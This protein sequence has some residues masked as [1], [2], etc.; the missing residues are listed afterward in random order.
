M[1]ALLKMQ[2]KEATIKKGDNFETISIDDVKVHDIVMVKPGESIPVDGIV[3]EGISVV[4]ESMLTGESAPVDKNVNSKVFAGTINKD[5][6][7]LVEAK[8]SRAATALG[9]IIKLV[10][11][12]SASKAP[13]QKLA[14]KVSS[15]F[16]P[17]VLAAAVIS[18]ILWISF[19]DD[20]EKSIISAVSVLVIACPCAL[21]LATPTVILVAVA[22]GA[23][24]GILVKSAEA[25]QNATKMTKLIIDKTGTVTE[26]VVKFDKVFSNDEQAFL[27]IAK[28]LSLRSTHPVSKAIV[29]YAQEKQIQ[30]IGIDEYHSLSGKGVEAVIEGEK[31]CFGSL[32]F[33]KEKHLDTSEIEGSFM[34]QDQTCVILSNSK[35]ALGFCTF[36]DPIKEGTQE[37]LQELSRLKIK[38]YLISGDRKKAVEKVAS[39]LHFDG[40]EGEVLPKEKAAYVQKFKAEQDVV[41][42]VGDGVNDAPALATADV[43][44]AMGSGADVAMESASIGLMKPDLKLLVSSIKLSKFTKSKI[45][46]NLSFAFV[47]NIAGI[48]IAAAGLLNPMIAGAAMALSS[49][50]VV[51]NAVFLKYKRID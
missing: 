32:N 23:K 18:F 48:P 4:D 51:L 10:E 16:V 17:C 46:Q 20:M 34:D 26:G 8:A 44:F 35:K 7:L 21:G 15:V 50:C 42:M 37:A 1:T 38:T 45:Y 28:A 40:S 2:P 22:K 13:A 27:K 36:I 12:A 33:M 9:R 41:G 5:G 14:D 24:A 25:F 30:D 6:S 47:Y 29:N 31:Y 43:G 11:K 39:Q 3:T 19:S 49:I